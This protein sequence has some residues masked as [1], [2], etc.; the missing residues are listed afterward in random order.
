MSVAYLVLSDGT[1]YPGHS[2]GAPPKPASHA[3]MDAGSGAF[4]EVVFNTSMAGYQEMLTDP[5]YAGQILVPT[6]PLQG[7]YGISA[8]GGTR[9][10]REKRD[11][12]VGR[13]PPGTEV[14]PGRWL[15]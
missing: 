8:D 13:R 10:P 5:S 3:E 6:Y 7:N 1:V 9:Q 11:E 2:F 4:G 15:R 12:K 14:Q